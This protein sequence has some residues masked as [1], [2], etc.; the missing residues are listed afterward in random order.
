MV[1]EVD[2]YKQQLEELEKRLEN[3][4]IIS[5]VQAAALKQLNSEKL[6]TA[7]HLIVEASESDPQSLL[8]P[9]RQGLDFKSN[10]SSPMNNLEHKSLNVFFG[11]N[12]MSVKETATVHMTT[13]SESSRSNLS[14]DLR[15]ASLPGMDTD[16]KSKTLKIPLEVRTLQ[17]H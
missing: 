12:F 7:Q 8:Q 6:L 4:K 14:P 13:P 15:T 2:R 3:E 11:D 16:S 10:S 17:L 9:E 1:L 5:E